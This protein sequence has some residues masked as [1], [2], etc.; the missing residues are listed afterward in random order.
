MNNSE[1]RNKKIIIF[2]FII[3]SILILG[4]AVFNLFFSLNIITSTE[5]NVSD[6]QL[7]GRRPALIRNVKMLL[8]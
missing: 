7:V 8:T 5:R 4:F 1:D 6:Y 3:I 2:K